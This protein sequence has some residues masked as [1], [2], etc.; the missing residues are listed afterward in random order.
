LRSGDRA[1]LWDCGSGNF[2][3]GR[4]EIPAAV[5]ALRARIGASAPQGLTVFVTHPDLDHVSA[6]LDVVE[7][8]GVTKVVVGERFHAD[9]RRSRGHGPEALV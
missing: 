6:L 1:A 8:L 2:A 9:A 3:M 7:P 5:R 4:R